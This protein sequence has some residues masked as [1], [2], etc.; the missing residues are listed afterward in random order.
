LFLNYFKINKGVCLRSKPSLSKEV[1]L[2]MKIYLNDV[3]TEIDSSQTI[4]SIMIKNKLNTNGIALA[5][6]D[7]VISKQKWASTLL[8]END[9]MFIITATAGG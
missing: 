3:P 7:V 2:K 4:E 8:N 1:I 6:N 5:I 9:K